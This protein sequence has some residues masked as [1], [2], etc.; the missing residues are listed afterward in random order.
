VF[1]FLAICRKR[2]IQSKQELKPL[3]QDLVSQLTRMVTPQREGAYCLPFAL[4]LLETLTLMLRDP[5]AEIS[6]SCIA[7]D[8]GFFHIL[9]EEH[10]ESSRFFKVK[11]A[12]VYI[13]K[14]LAD[15]NS[16]V[17]S[18]ALESLNRLLEIEKLEIWK[19]IDLFLK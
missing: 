7:I 4:C 6:N 3:K 16:K 14:C 1:A 17:K 11:E 10:L 18:W 15:T 12:L 19:Y 8:K 9:R 2:L 13:A 5:D